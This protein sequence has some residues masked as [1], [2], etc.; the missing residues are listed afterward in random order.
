MENSLQES[1]YLSEKRGRH[2]FISN[3]IMTEAQR[4]TGVKDGMIFLEELSLKATLRFIKILR[5]KG[6]NMRKYYM[7]H[8]VLGYRTTVRCQNKKE[9]KKIFKNMYGVN[10][11]EIEFE[12][13]D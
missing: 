10:P 2:K 5:F 1:H 4:N 9:A 6:D 7:I 8:I 13:E 3:K 12:E 11:D